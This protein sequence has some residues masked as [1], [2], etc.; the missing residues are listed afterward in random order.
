MKKENIVRYTSEEIEKQ[1]AEGEGKTDWKRVDAMTEEEIHEAALSD[2]DAQPTDYEFWENAKVVTPD[3]RAKKQLTIRVDMD[4]YEWFKATGRGY[5]TL[6][7]NVLKSYVEA[8]N[9]TGGDVRQ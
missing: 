4:V 8:Q 2:P 1:L 3:M 9:E 5:Q 7:N 6:M